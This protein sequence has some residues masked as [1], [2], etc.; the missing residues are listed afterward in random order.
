MLFAA[1][2]LVHLAAIIAAPDPDVPPGRQ[3][4][5]PSNAT[6]RAKQQR[7]GI[8]SRAAS[9]PAGKHHPC[10]ATASASGSQRQRPGSC[11]SPMGRLPRLP[12]PME[13]QRGDEQ[14]GTNKRYVYTFIAQRPVRAVK[15]KVHSLTHRDDETSAPAHSGISSRP[16]RRRRCA[17][18]AARRSSRVDHGDARDL[19]TAPAQQHSQCACVVG[20]ATQVEL[21]THLLPGRP[22]GRFDEA[23]P[24]S[25]TADGLNLFCR[26]WRR[27]S[28]ARGRLSPQVSARWQVRPTHIGSLR[29]GGV[30]IIR[31][32]VR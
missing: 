7:I 28:A 8:G 23:V 11:T 4:L 2:R 5:H 6:D 1:S 31:C 16:A 17:A 10:A 13:T 26:A 27:E 18:H 9:K 20:I 19:D 3:R 25:R 32:A 21:N 12:H 24:W 15:A 30:V 29:G 22:P 14:R